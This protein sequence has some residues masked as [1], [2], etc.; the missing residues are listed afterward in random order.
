MKRG[1]SMLFALAT[2]GVMSSC[3]SGNEIQAEFVN[4]RLVKIDTI[5]RHPGQEVL[6]TFRCQNRLKMISFVPLSS[7]YNVGTVYQVLMTK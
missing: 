2:A 5:Y 4:A 6:L 3:Y 7:H 1:L